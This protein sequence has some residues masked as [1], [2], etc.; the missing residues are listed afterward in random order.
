MPSWRQV[1]AETTLPAPVLS[2]RRDEPQEGRP[3]TTAGA[4]G[5]DCIGAPFPLHAT[6]DTGNAGAFTKTVEGGFPF[7]IPPEADADVSFEPDLTPLAPRFDQYDPGAAVKLETRGITRQ[8]QQGKLDFDMDACC[9]SI[10]AKL[11]EVGRFDLIGNAA[12][13]HTSRF[14]ARCCKCG[15]HHEYWNRCELF[16]CPRCQSRLARDR[17]RSVEWWTENIKQPKHLVLTVRNSTTITKQYVRWFKDCFT[18]LRRSAVW[19]PVRGGLYSLEVTN[20]GRGWH[21][22]M[23]ILIDCNYVD[24]SALTQ[25]W[26][27]IVGQDFAISKIKD[28]RGKDYV[29]EVTKYSVKGNQLAGWSGHDIAA[30]IDAFTGLRTFGVFGTLFSARA[31][32]TAFLESLDN[33]RQ[34]CECGSKEFRYFSD[35]EWEWEQIR[36]DLSP[37][38]VR[39]QTP[40]DP[41]TQPT[42]PL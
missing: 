17:R 34:Q 38:P 20:E 13:C 16:W 21:L 26:A 28:V 3:S 23:H 32:H 12:V 1:N 6:L 11:R 40:A 31:G 33:D 35:A 37:P 5:S 15:K 8:A 14:H 4:P 42:L 36:S 39:R 18:R 19:Q 9:E 27:A 30:F 2:L 29:K 22:H 41:T 24:I 7:P 25:R 10:L